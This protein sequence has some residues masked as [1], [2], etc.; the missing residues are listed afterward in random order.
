MTKKLPIG[1]VAAYNKVSRKERK[2]LDQTG[3]ATKGR[4][5][6]RTDKRPKS[7]DIPC[8]KSLP[9]GYRGRLESIDYR[10]HQ[11][12]SQKRDSCAIHS[13][14]MN[15]FQSIHRRRRNSWITFSTT[16]LRWSDRLSF[17]IDFLYFVLIG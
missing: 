14:S 10:V 2:L 9:L 5:G 3:E 15:Q 8:G 1:H 4:E 11:S 13:S 12:K 7:D 6:V 16:L 17:V